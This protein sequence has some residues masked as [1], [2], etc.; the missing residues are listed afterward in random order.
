MF[1][2]YGMKI[3]SSGRMRIT[4][5][6][7]R[8]FETDAA[9]ISGFGFGISGNLIYGVN[10]YLQDYFVCLNLLLSDNKCQV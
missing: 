4:A 2:D 6:S 10:S 5:L 1:F 7:C 9:M 3:A 8:L